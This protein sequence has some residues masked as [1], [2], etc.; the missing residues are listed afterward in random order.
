MIDQFRFGPPGVEVIESAGAVKKHV[1]LSRVRSKSRYRRRLA[2]GIPNRNAK[3]TFEPVAYMIGANMMIVH[4]Y[5]AAKMKE[6][7]K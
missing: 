4:P 1:D 5:I 7:C 2:K 3:I 6:R